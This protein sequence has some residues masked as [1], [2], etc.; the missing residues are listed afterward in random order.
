MSESTIFKSTP[1]YPTER[2]LNAA[3][4]AQNTVDHVGGGITLEHSGVQFVPVITVASPEL[5]YD[6]FMVAGLD[7]LAAFAVSQA[8][9]QEAERTYSENIAYTEA[10]ELAELHEISGAQLV[11]SSI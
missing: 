7:K 9:Q 3:W 8:A 6:Q 4:I 11:G 10:R 5:T 2:E 1:K